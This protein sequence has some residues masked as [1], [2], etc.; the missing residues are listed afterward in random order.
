MKGVRTYSIEA[1]EGKLRC[2]ARNRNKKQME[3]KREMITKLEN[4]YTYIHTQFSI[5]IT[6]NPEIKLRRINY[7]HI[8]T[9]TYIGHI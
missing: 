8:H 2:L 5:C 6:V 1:L 4:I 7:I 3:S 9:H